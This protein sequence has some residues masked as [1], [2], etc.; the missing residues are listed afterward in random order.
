MNCLPFSP[1][2]LKYDY[3]CPIVKSVVEKAQNQH[4]VNVTRYRSPVDPFAETLLLL[5]R[6]QVICLTQV[7]RT[8]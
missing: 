2:A 8:Q 6:C 5:M 7:I 3:Y 1:S 4:P